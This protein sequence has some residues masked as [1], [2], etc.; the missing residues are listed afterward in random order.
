MQII[1]TISTTDSKK[2]Y[3]SLDVFTNYSYIAVSYN[4]NYDSG[5]DQK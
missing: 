2:G 5:D 1:S 3:F 4:D